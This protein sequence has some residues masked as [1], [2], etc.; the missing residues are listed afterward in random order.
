MRKIIDQKI[1]QKSNRSATATPAPSQAPSPT[2]R[3]STSQQ[4]P[5]TQIAGFFDHISP[6]DQA[7]LDVLLTRVS[8][9]SDYI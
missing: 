4:R 9:K 7:E 1:N 8:A 5:Q 3:P 6:E 2:N